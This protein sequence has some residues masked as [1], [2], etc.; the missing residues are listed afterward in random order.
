VRFLKRFMVSFGLIS[1]SFDAATFLTL[2]WGFQASVETFR[3]AWFV[4][5]LLTE[6]LVLLVL[7]TRRPFWRSRPHQA[8]LVS[9]AL[10]VAVAV[11]LPLSPVAGALGFVPLEA[12]MWA[13]V[14]VIA[15]SYVLT[16]EMVKRPLLA[17]IEPTDRPGQE[18]G[19]VVSANL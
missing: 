14:F 6:L 15:V 2:T 13:A 19:P 8:L 12:S 1:A 18:G 10:V 17:V 5:S 11:C 7:R 9:T 16:V 4:E 3:T